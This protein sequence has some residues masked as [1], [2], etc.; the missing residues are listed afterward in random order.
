MWFQV[1]CYAV[2]ALY[3]FGNSGRNVMIAPG[4]WIWDFGAHKDF[5]LTEKFGLTFRSEFFNFLNKANF[6]YPNTSIGGAT[7]G[8]IR[9]AGPGRQ[10]QFALRLHF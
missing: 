8:T 4:L 2:P 1:S 6:G 10:I 7:A 9:S 3:T 5:R